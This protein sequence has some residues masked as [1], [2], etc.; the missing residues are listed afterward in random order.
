MTLNTPV[1]AIEPQTAEELGNNIF[2]NMKAKILHVLSIYPRISP[3]MLQVGIGTGISPDVW[4]P[5]LE[6]LIV[7]GFVEK[8][9]VRAGT[10]KG[11]DQVYTIIALKSPEAPATA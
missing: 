8:I 2:E 3:T 1:K 11:R 6:H 4:H 10:P 7:D 5:V 9:Q